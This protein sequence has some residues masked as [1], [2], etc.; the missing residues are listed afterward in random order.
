M[1]E[2]SFRRGLALAAFLI[3]PLV[4]LSQAAQQTR[5]LI[6]NGQPGEVALLQVEG[7]SYVEV[8]ALTRLANGS[9]SFRGNQ[10][11]LTL[12][13]CSAS[14]AS[15][16]HG[17]PGFSKEFLRAGIEEMGV[18]REWR[19]A[20]INA[21]QR[22]L[23]VTEEWVR[24]LRG[25]ATNNLSLASLA[26][27]TDDDRSALQL[28]TNE[29]NFMTRLSDRLV[30]AGKSV[31]YISPDNLNSD[32]LN[33][34]IVACGRALGAMAASGQFFDDG[35]CQDLDGYTA[36]LPSAAQRETASLMAAATRSIWWGVNSGYIGRERTSSA[37]RSA[38]GIPPGW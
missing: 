10:T 25:T 15:N 28:L 1:R 31:T 21:I 9:I 3:V 19:S 11:L 38:W 14:A 17:A 2:T 5:T 20:V 13:D 16:Q 23:P 4:A 6:V 30:A 36:L 37:A 33:Q 27:N 34:R 18:I 29:F 22:G 32:P 7:R 26:V 8:E 24:G 35:S 12:P